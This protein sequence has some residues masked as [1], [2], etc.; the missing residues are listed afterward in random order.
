MKLL[1]AVPSNIASEFSWWQQD[2]RSSSEVSNY[3]TLHGSVS[4]DVAIIGG[5]FTGMWTALI[6]KERQPHLRVAVLDAF[7]CGDGASSRNGGNVH[8]YWGALPTLLPMFGANKALEAAHLGTLAQRRLS[9]FASNKDRDVWWEEKG[10]IRVSTSAAQS[11]KIDE[12]IAVANSLGVSTTLTRLSQAETNA[13]CQSEMFQE[14]LL[15]EEGATVHPARL[16][17]HLRAAIADAGVLVFEDTPVIAINKGQTCR[18]QTG[19][20]E[21]IARDVV[22]A[23]YTGTMDINAVSR[24]TSLFS[25]FPVM[26]AAN[27][28]ELEKR[29]YT[30][31]RGLADLRMFTHYFRRTRDGRILMGSGSGPLEKGNAHLSPK[32][33]NDPSSVQRAEVGLKRFFPNMSGGIAARW[34]FPIEVTADRLPFFGTLPGTRIHYGSGYSGHGVN[35]TVLAGECISSLILNENDKW[36][37]SV[38]CHRQRLTFPPEP[39][40][41]I[42]GLMVRD[43]IVRCEDAEDAGLPQ[44]ALA[45]AIANLPRIIGM[46][47]GTR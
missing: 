24:S 41:Y 39:F 13:L 43:S 47:V 27:P 46:R 32:L 4:V 11:K 9:Q 40:R 3:R 6:L 16:A 38:F 7:R 28:E 2:I 26:S 31:A 15:F 17:N 5:G 29:N 19:S 22:L 35:A 42:G 25:S 21:V 36:S 33:R 44:P 18:V 12:L 34:G 14:S 1:S 8:G 23:T 30:I 10:Y 20:G 37:N 45:R